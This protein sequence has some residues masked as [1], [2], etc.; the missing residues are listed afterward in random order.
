MLIVSAN[1][2]RVQIMVELQ[3][4]VIQLMWVLG[5]EL[6]PLQGRLQRQLASGRYS[7]RKE[8]G[9]FTWPLRAKWAQVA[10]PQKHL[11]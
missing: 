7:R 1:V 11:T 6:H 8:G 10:F 2:L 4:V 3:A 5:T 9:T